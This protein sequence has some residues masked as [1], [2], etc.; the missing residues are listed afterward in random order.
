M[1]AEFGFLFLKRYIYIRNETVPFQKCR[2]DQMKPLDFEEKSNV[3]LFGICHSP[4]PK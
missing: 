1:A 2:I 3:V 4:A